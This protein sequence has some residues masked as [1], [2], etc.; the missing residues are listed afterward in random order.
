[1]VVSLLL[2]G[3][4]RTVFKWE[5]EDESGDRSGERRL[6]SFGEKPEAQWSPAMVIAATFLTALL[7]FR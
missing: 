6:I 3:D 2:G 5:P 1:M 7:R 4:D